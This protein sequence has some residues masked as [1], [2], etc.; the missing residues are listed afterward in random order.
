M[1]TTCLPKRYVSAREQP[2]SERRPAMILL[3][4]VVLGALLSSNAPAQCNAVISPRLWP[5]TASAMRP[6]SSRIFTAA[7]DA[8]TA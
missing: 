4:L 5:M 2:R 6:D 3:A 7:S 8:V 1:L